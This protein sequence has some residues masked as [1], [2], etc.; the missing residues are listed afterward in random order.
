MAEGDHPACTSEARKVG[1]AAMHRSSKTLAGA[2]GEAPLASWYPGYA[3]GRQPKFVVCSSRSGTYLQRFGSCS[4]LISFM[5]SGLQNPT[6]REIQWTVAC[7]ILTTG[8]PAENHHVFFD[9]Q[10]LKLTD[11]H[12]WQWENNIAPTLRLEKPGQE[13]MAKQEFVIALSSQWIFGL[14]ERLRTLRDNIGVRV[15]HN[16]K[17]FPA[18]F[19]PL[20]SFFDELAELRM[21]VAKNQTRRL[22]S[23]N[24]PGAVFDLETGSAGWEFDRGGQ[25]VNVTRRQIAEKFLAAIRECRQI[26]VAKT[27]DVNIQT[28]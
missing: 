6:P 1:D 18:K 17:E 12:A 10:G 20:N 19:A 8:S 28:T 16:R 14:Y 11:I 21:V 23:E 26:A 5:S 7:A 25:K 22:G 2:R 9:F 13:N 4:E 15:S 3:S 27:A 24:V